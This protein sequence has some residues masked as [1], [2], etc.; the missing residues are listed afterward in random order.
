MRQCFGNSNCVEWTT[1]EEEHERAPLLE[2]EYYLSSS[3]DDSSYHK[4]GISAAVTTGRYQYQ[5]Y[6]IYVFFV[7]F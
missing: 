6:C 7:P 3:F 4:K 1:I 2:K 5:I